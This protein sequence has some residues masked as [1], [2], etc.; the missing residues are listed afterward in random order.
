MSSGYD[1]SGLFETNQKTVAVFTSKCS[2][3]IMVNI[4]MAAKGLSF[5][6]TEVKDFKIRLQETVVEK[7]R[8]LA[9]TTEVFEVVSEVAVTE[10]EKEGGRRAEKY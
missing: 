6:V 3:S 4:A 5:M 9:I 7:K 10:S 2:A 8:Q 1:L